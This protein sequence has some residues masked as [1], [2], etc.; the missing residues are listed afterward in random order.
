MATEEAMNRI[1]LYS[2]GTF[3]AK[4]P[5]PST[6]CKIKVVVTTPEATLAQAPANRFGEFQLGFVPEKNLRISFG[7]VGGNELD[8]I[9][10]NGDED[11]PSKLKFRLHLVSQRLAHGLR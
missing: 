10:W 8:S 11:S 1:Y 7:I 3:H 5:W 9:G 4:R 2:Y 6:V